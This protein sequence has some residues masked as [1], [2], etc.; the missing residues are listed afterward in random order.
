MGGDRERLISCSRKAAGDMKE[1]GNRKK[2]KKLTKEERTERMGGE[3][4][5]N[6]H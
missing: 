4:R 2:N 1:V 3:Q 6:T 5:L